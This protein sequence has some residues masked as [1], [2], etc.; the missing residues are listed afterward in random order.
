MQPSTEFFV[1]INPSSEFLEILGRWML[2]N[3]PPIAYTQTQTYK[4]AIHKDKSTLN[5]T[6]PLVKVNL[7]N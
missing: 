1:L 5:K 3:L 4:I 7:D 6:F 2:P